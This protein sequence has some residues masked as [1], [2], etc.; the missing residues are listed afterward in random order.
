MTLEYSPNA[1]RRAG[2]E[3]ATGKVDLDMVRS[4]EARACASSKRKRVVLW[5]HAAK[6]YGPVWH[7]RVNWY[8]LQGA[9]VCPGDETCHWCNETRKWNNSQTMAC[10]RC[11]QEK[12]RGRFPLD[13]MPRSAGR[14]RSVC[15]TCVRRVERAEAQAAKAYRE[16]PTKVCSACKVEKD[17]ADF[18]KHKAKGNRTT[19]D[20]LESQCKQ[21]KISGA[22]RRRRAKK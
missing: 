18:Y 14:R 1:A 8:T 9:R 11:G 21:C 13:V 17:K 16:H 19:A 7:V 6:L 4:V 15:L 3:R 12:P 5:D 10:Q 2:V 22:Q 20:G